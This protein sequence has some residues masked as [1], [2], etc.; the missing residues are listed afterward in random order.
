MVSFAKYR[1]WLQLQLVVPPDSYSLTER[2]LEFVVL[3]QPKSQRIAVPHYQTGT[4]CSCVFPGGTGYLVHRMRYSVLLLSRLCARRFLWPQWGAPLVSQAQVPR[5]AGIPSPSR[6]YSSNSG[7]GR[8]NVLVVGLPNPVI[9][10]RSRI[11]FFLIRAYFD[12]EFNIE[13]F[14]DG[15]KQAFTLVSKLLSQCK[16]DALQNLISGELLE[17]IKE[18]CSSLSDNH[19]NALAAHLD[20]IMYTTTGDVAIYYDDNGRKFVSILMRFWYLTCAELPDDSL[21]GTKVF[22]FI[23][24]D[25]NTKNTKRLLTAN[26][27][28]RREFTQGVTPDWIITRIEHSKLID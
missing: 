16:F 28:F 24:G 18:K 21:E 12:R 22:Q 11:Y 26:Y 13:E 9:W 4:C 25:E 3:Q 5:P 2:V 6:G 10:F 17:D 8:R 1:S 23:M 14:T 19:R 27:E 20:E 15:A 7:T